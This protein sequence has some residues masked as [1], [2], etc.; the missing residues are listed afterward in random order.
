M[1]TDDEFPNKFKTKSL[2]NKLKSTIKIYR[3]RRNPQPNY[4][5]ECNYNLW[6]TYS[7]FPSHR[8]EVDFH[9]L[10]GGTLAEPSVKIKFN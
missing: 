5:C 3:G 10:L 2:L 6:K 4:Q 8:L 1:T 9:L 7:S